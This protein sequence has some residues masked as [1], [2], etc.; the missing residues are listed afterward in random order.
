MDHI[1]KFSKP[2]I[3]HARTDN[4]IDPR[5]FCRLRFSPILATGVVVDI[6]REHFGTPQSIIDPMLQNYIWEDTDKSGIIIETSTNEKLTQISQRPA[7]LVRRDDIRS[8]RR[9]IGDEYSLL[10]NYNTRQFT[11]SF[12]GSHTIFNIAAKAGHAEA[13]ANESA[14]LLLGFSS[15]ICQSLC[16]EDFQLEQIGKIAKL[17]GSGGQYVIP[18]TFSYKASFEWS[19]DENLPPIRHVD[20]KLLFNLE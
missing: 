7:I 10:T 6:L 9:I 12:E 15:L 18:A 4:R 20:T 1:Q 16:F 17:E 19:L 13:L 5:T 2:E 14:W 11:R 3:T 8:S